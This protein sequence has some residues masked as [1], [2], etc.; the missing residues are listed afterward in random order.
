MHA[1]VQAKLRVLDVQWRT[2]PEELA[3][4]SWRRWINE[5]QIFADDMTALF[6]KLS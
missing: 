6:L 3:R 1:F 4:E 5:E 2:A